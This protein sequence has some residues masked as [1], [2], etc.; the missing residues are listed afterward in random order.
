MNLNIELQPVEEENP[1]LTRHVIL[2]R[3]QAS[4]SQ[5]VFSVPFG[6]SSEKIIP[7]RDYP[8]EGLSV[9]VEG[10]N[11]HFL[12]GI[13]VGAKKGSRYIKLRAKKVT[14]FPWEMIYYYENEEEGIR[15]AITY[16]LMNIGAR[17][18]GITACVSLESNASSIVIEPIVDIRHMYDESA[19]ERHFCKAL[20]DG[21]LIQRDEK[22][23]S[24]RTVNKCEVRTWKKKIE[25]WYKLG[26][27]SRENTDGEVV[28][29]GEIKNPVSLGEMEVPLDNTSTALLVI[30][31][32]NSETQLEW[33]NE[34][35]KEWLRDERK[36]E[37][38]AF[39]IVKSPGI[40]NPAIAFRALAL[41]KFGML[42]D[43]KF[44][45]EAGDFWFRTPWF[46]DQFEGIINNIETL[47]RI[48]HAER[49]RDIILRAFEYQDEYGRIP[50]R[51]PERKGGELDYSNADATL[52]AFIAAG[53]FLKRRKDEKFASTILGRAEFT[54]SRFKMNP[55]EKINGAPVLN[56]N[57]LISVI[58]W[59]SWTD[60][61]RGIEIE[62][63]RVKVSVRIPDSWC[64]AGDENELNKP[65]YFLPEINAQWIKMLRSCV[66]MCSSNSNPENENKK[67]EYSALL[68]KAR[69]NFKKV[70]WD[71]E[72][73]ILYNLVTVNGKKDRTPGSPA[74]V[75]FSLLLDE[76]VF[77]QYE[78]T[79]FIKEVKENLLVEKNGLPF[80]ILVKKSSKKTYYGDEE[81]HEAVIWP[82]DT[83]YLIRILQAAG[84]VEK[85][86]V[87]G[88]LRSNLEHQMNEGFVFYNSELFSPDKGEIV[89]VKNPV[90]FW[91][92]WADAFLE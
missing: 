64:D 74:V 86:T 21:M 22:R 8:Y 33:L 80:G 77:S 46:R 48:G 6:D 28:F 14:A 50:N 91:S 72:E 7:N 58:P 30:S 82:R 71:A 70:F 18:K 43:K 66:N 24:L 51:F 16:Y 1:A 47:F 32:S 54:I 78:L 11:F 35:G 41:S 76:N 57:G 55:L 3:P 68:E 90:Q 15:L 73:N 61:K 36:E 92:Q 37:K 59:H 29:K 56:E 17:Q 19:S 9:L 26:S 83:P 13:A 53:E 84:E 87:E 38:K 34:K 31:C 42:A 89:P 81:Y 69:K 27:G 49:I 65:K 20:S 52:L 88:I 44:F 10:E 4:W 75:A 63:K 40:N 62:G 85:E 79:E 45:Y 23:I 5:S 39:G 25:W 67:D 12:D 60:T 2:K